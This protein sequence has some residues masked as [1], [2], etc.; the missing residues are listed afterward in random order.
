MIST[1]SVAAEV[2]ELLEVIHALKQAAEVWEKGARV[3]H[4]TKSGDDK[5]DLE[6]LIETTNSIIDNINSVA[7]AYLPNVPESLDAL[8][9]FLDGMQP[10]V[11]ELERRLVAGELASQHEFTQPKS[12]WLAVDRFVAEITSETS[13]SYSWEERR[14][15]SVGA[16][17]TTFD[18]YRSGVKS[19]ATAATEINGRAGVPSGTIVEIMATLDQAGVVYFTFPFRPHAIAFSGVCMVQEDDDSNPHDDEDTMQN[20]ATFSGSGITYPAGGGGSVGDEQRLLLRLATPIKAGQPFTIF[21]PIV[22]DATWTWGETP[23]STYARSDARFQARLVSE[24]FDPATATWANQ[25]AAALPVGA[26]WAYGNG[27][28]V[29]RCYADKIEKIDFVQE[30]HSSISGGVHKDTAVLLGY[31]VVDYDVYG[32]QI[33]V[34]GYYLDPSPTTDTTA[35]TDTLADYAGGGAALW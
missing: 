28:I 34:D 2:S 31:G 12:V 25:P 29:L 7:Q 30:Y 21:V 27:L 3:N 8:V 5:R 18:G 22:H 17:W 14:W 19:T 10:Q 15:E 24:T 13:G 26:G 16:A 1:E 6:T 23:Y 35:A 33:S 32:V 20:A 9:G 11:E 4:I